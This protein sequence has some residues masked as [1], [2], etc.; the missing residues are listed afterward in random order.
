MGEWPSQTVRDFRGRRLPELAIPSGYAA[1]ISR[2]DLS[3]PLPPRLAAIAERH[4]PVSTDDW[5]LLTPRH[6]AEPT[7]AGQ[8]VFALKWEGI[9]LGV[10]A[11]LF[12]V[13]GADPVRDLILATPTGAFARRIWYLY[14]WLTSTEL[15][16]PDPGKV[17]A[18]SIVDTDLQFG[19]DHGVASAR[20]KVVDNLP[21]SPAF[22]PMVRRT[23][24][25]EEAG[26]KHL[27][28]IARQEVGR[29]RAD[30]VSRAAAFLLLNDSKSSFAIEGER[31]SGTR[32]IR[33]GQAIAQAGSHPLS[34]AELD[35]LQ[36]I[37]IG[38]ARF[39][40]LG[41]RTQGGFVGVHDR[42][43]G[44]PLPDHISAR[45]EDLG[46]LLDGIVAYAD[47]T[48]SQG[49]DPVVAAAAIAFGF[50]YIHPYEDGNGR[51]HR[52]L[53]HHALASANY[54]PPGLVFP[55]SAAILR[56]LDAYRLVLESYSRPLLQEIEWQRTA[57]G[58]VEVLNQTINFYRY[59]DATAHAEFLY[60]C[61]EQT[62]VE[63]LPREVR[64]LEAFD[65]FSDGIQQ[66]VDM[67]DAQVELLQKFLQ[68][69]TGQFSQRARSREFAALTDDEAAQ[70][71]QLYTDAF[72][73]E[74]WQP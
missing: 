35:R 8:L 21:G 25:L 67:P 4:H 7:L 6:Q 40:R 42:D 28:Q 1:L 70:I 64:F 3:L 66:I 2:Y 17:K 39:V 47:R 22:C 44:D 12:A 58:N 55:V 69:N 31:P 16:I 68:Q 15:D 65:R 62:I 32:A 56:R 37:V 14:E 49:Y 18:V 74:D 19:L 34:L 73:D 36:R 53:I 9:D 71:E 30:L 20:H 60:D 63:D 61:V 72:G 10:L 46:I 5:T 54:N 38:D 59:F 29:I 24:R 48:R 51:I 52:W 50:V 43:N 23:P 13:L 33:W 11:Q 41:L 26:T 57:D 45:H 27:D